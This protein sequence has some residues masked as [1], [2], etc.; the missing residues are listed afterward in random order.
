MSF[1][2]SALSAR[3]IGAGSAGGLAF[4]AT[5]FGAEVRYGQAV[6]R[7]SLN[8]L[9]ETLGQV[10]AFGSPTR[11][12]LFRAVGL[13]P[14]V[15][16]AWPYSGYTASSQTMLAA[17]SAVS[18][19]GYASRFEPP[20][21]SANRTCMVDGFKASVFGAPALNARLLAQA[22][23]R[24]FFSSGQALARSLMSTAGSCATQYGYA[25][26][27]YRMRAGGIAETRFGSHRSGRSFV[28]MPIVPK[29]RIGQ[30]SA[31]GVASEVHRAFH[32]SSRARFG[33]PQG[34][35]RNHFAASGVQFFAPGVGHG[36][37]SRHRVFAIAPAACIGRPV[38]ERIYCADH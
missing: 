19:F 30:P 38:I 32:I 26:S 35:R 15:Q 1:A 21:S 20:I 22:E 23:G 3:S 29:T 4:A 2:S 10:S 16:W 5:G 7:F 12:Y 24:E 28:A 33:A 11:A 17:G 18:V 31:T 9:P 6:V 36:S 27:T 13:G 37:I 14:M 8:A 34:F 25:V